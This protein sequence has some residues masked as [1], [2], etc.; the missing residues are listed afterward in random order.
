[1]AKLYLSILIDLEERTH[2]Q[3]TDSNFQEITSF[4]SVGAI[5]TA[6]VFL[7][8]LS[9]RISEQVIF[10]HS[11]LHFARILPYRITNVNSALYWEEVLANTLV[12]MEV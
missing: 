1:M 12:H 4:L 11:V 8:L 7:K 5:E 9:T 2:L 10:S 3:N 6:E